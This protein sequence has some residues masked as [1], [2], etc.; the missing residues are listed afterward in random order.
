MPDKDIIIFGWR[1]N[2]LFRIYKY[3]LGLFH[4]SH[5]HNIHLYIQIY[6]YIFR[7]TLYIQNRY[8]IK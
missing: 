6:K 8:Y 1:Q 3:I 2:Y 4:N 5:I 7:F